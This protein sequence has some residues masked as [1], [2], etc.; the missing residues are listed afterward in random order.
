MFDMLNG[1]LNEFTDVLDIFI[2]D[3]SFVFIISLIH[4]SMYVL[5]LDLDIILVA[6]E[7]PT[8]NMLR[9]LVKAIRCKIKRKIKYSANL[10]I[11]KENILIKEDGP[12]KK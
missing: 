6:V 5:D 12:K 1:L 4:V 10:P 9:Q 7:I 11:N 8:M 3:V 2:R